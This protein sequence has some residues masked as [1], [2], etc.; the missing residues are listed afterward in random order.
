MTV[1]FKFSD[2]SKLRETQLYSRE[3]NI[4]DPRQLEMYQSDND[5]FYYKPHAMKALYPG[6]LVLKVLA[7]EHPPR[8]INLLVV[9]VVNILL[10]GCGGYREVIT[11]LQMVGRTGR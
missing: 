3:I 5:E 9:L 4:N 6:K 10:S 2:R 7:S 8:Q 1:A 11:S